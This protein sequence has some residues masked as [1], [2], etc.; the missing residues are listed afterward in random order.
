[1][2]TAEGLI[3]DSDETIHRT[4]ASSSPAIPIIMPRVLRELRH[5]LRSRGYA[6]AQEMLTAV[7]PAS[8]RNPPFELHL[9][10]R[11]FARGDTLPLAEA[12]QALRPLDPARLIHAG[13]MQQSGATVRALFQIQ[14][15]RGL[16]FI[17]DFMPHEHPADL[18]LPIGPS[19]KY[20]ASLTIRNRVSTG[21][22]LG[23]GCGIQALLMASHAKRVTATDVNPRALELTRL[24]A[25]L[26]NIR[27]IETHEGSFFEPV[28]GR[29]FDLIVANLPYVITPENR[30][31]YRDL[32]HGDDA[33][34]RENVEQMPSHLTEGGYAQVMLNWIHRADQAWW[35]PIES[36]I[37][38]RNADAW[39][40]YTSSMTPEQYAK[41]WMTIN[42]NEQPEKYAETKDRW[43]KWYAAQG[44][45]RIGF[46]A[47]ALRRRTSADN[48]RCSVMVDKTISE[49]LGEHVAH[50]FRSQDQLAVVKEPRGLLER[51]LRPWNSWLRPA[52]EDLY[53]VR[54]VSG[55]MLRQNVHPATAATISHL[56]GKIKLRQ[57]IQ[58]AGIE[59][60]EPAAMQQIL[61]E[62]YQLMKLGLIAAVK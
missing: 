48:W 9:L 38:R 50:L 26:N 17:V 20:L 54:T 23:C 10:R 25:A 61:D 8:L 5:L 15:Y 37:T 47:L 41:L 40:I 44:I 56:D 22:D 1:M 3:N 31:V 55:F 49:P 58:R 32:G 27:N 45:E 59:A 51:V 2:A 34:I 39:L 62:I 24:N 53:E 16:L 60:R 29:Q 36:W 28:A 13:L 12:A 57:A 18:V 21:L 4:G 14:V 30:F 19:G 11:L 7:Q 46:G 6:A 33:P 43:L 52:T 42:A 35:Q